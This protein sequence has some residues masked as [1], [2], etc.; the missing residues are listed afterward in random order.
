MPSLSLQN[1][2]GLT[3]RPQKDRYRFCDGTGLAPS[4]TTVLV[5]IRE[6]IG[7]EFDDRAPRVCAINLYLD[8]SSKNQVL[9]LELASKE[10]S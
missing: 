1:L 2:C 4:S 6:E 9:T 8:C 5:H 7:L 10:P 3:K